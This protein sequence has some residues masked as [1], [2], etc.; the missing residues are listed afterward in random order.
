M[1]PMPE[2]LVRV[3]EA[4]I[5]KYPARCDYVTIGF[6]ACYAALADGAGEFDQV[7]AAQDEKLCPPYSRPYQIWMD[8][9]KRQWSIGAARIALAEQKYL[10]CRDGHE[11][12]VHKTEKHIAHLEE[13]LRKAE[14][15]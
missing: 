10:D 8:G 14:G 3:R 4:L 2:S 12:Y 11:N 9:A 1:T 7:Q 6:D 13:R 15:K 5:S